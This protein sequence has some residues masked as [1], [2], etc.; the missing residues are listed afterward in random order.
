MAVIVVD[1][2]EIVD[3]E[4]GKRKW[5]GIVL[6]QQVVDVPFDHPPHRQPGQFVKI[7]AAEQLVLDRLLLAEIGGTG[8]QQFCVGDANRPMGVKE[9]PPDMSIGNAFLGDDGAIRAQQFDAGFAA[10]GQFRRGERRIRRG[11]EQILGGNLQACRGGVVDQQKTAVLVLHRYAGGKHPDDFIQQAQFGV[12]I[13]LVSRANRGGRSIRTDGSM[14]AVGR[15]GR[16]KL[17]AGTLHGRR[18]SQSLL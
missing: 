16:K 11:G 18:P 15:E 10:A 8:Q 6:M 2:L 3:V 12:D 9:C 1:V 14:F 13:A 17:F 7:G 4:E 5:F